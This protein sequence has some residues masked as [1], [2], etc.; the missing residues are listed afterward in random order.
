MRPSALNLALAVASSG[1]QQA[2]FRHYW[3]FACTENPHRPPALGDRREPDVGYWQ[4]VQLLRT[5][6]WR[7][8]RAGGGGDVVRS[9]HPA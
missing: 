6:L 5:Q 2:C 4:L 8:L 9:K 3:L 7:D 1:S